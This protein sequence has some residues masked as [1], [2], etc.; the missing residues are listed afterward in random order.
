MATTSPDNIWTPDAGDDYALTTDLATMADTIQAAIADRARTGVAN[1]ASASAR[2][3][4]YPTPVQG[5]SV[6]RLDKG[7]IE[8]YYATWNST[9][10]PGGASP[11]GWYPVAEGPRFVAEN[12]GTT[13]MSTTASFLS[14]NTALGSAS[15]WRNDG[16]T[17]G[18]GNID[19]PLP[20]LYDIAGTVIFPSSSAGAYRGVN[21]ASDVVGAGAGLTQLSFAPGS[22]FMYVTFTGTIP[23][24]SNFSVQARHDIGATQSLSL[25]MLSAQFA[26][27][28]RH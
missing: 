14:L 18:T 26:G 1:V 24:Q 19:V 12:L 22:G 25:R 11:A 13:V 28:R 4:L 3:V 21:L 16:F 7:W 6:R 27:V 20:G 8:T 9:T 10:N 2:D 17:T 15:V 23:V 5:D